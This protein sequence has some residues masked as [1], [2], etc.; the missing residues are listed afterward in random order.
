MK[1]KRLA[2]IFLALFAGASIAADA[3]G[4]SALAAIGPGRAH[5]TVTLSRMH[6]E[7][8]APVKKVSH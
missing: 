1:R 4:P 8:P 3:A 7:R 5:P 2:T 6:A